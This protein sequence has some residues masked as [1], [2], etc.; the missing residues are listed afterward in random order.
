LLLSSPS[1]SFTANWLR[2]TTH[3]L[4]VAAQKRKQ[5]LFVD[6]LQCHTC[7]GQL[8]EH[9]ILALCLDQPGDGVYCESLCAEVALA[10]Q[11]FEELMLVTLAA[12]HG[13]IQQRM[14]GGHLHVDM[15]SV[16]EE[17]S[18]GWQVVGLNY[19]F[20]VFEWWLR[21]QLVAS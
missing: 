14:A 11:Y 21:M 19:A 13:E 12:G 8:L 9:S 15:A 4:R 2:N 10:Q 16:F 20:E 17:T 18:G 1:I 3:Q 5:F 7:A 6:H